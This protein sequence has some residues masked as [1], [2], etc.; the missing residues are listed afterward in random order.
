MVING[1][2]RLDLAVLALMQASAVRTLVIAN[3]ACERGDL[4]GVRMP[5]G[6]S[7]PPIR[8][9]RGRATNCLKAFS[10]APLSTYQQ[11]P[12][13]AALAANEQHRPC[14][15]DASCPYLAQIESHILQ[16]VGAVFDS[17][18]PGL[19]N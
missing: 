10:K 18:A 19:A 12:D 11:T 3:A 9:I 15:F 13:A 5:P 16:Q 8:A 14:R 2:K 17:Q 7:A 1:G 6:V 4:K